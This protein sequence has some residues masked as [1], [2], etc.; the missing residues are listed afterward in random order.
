VNLPEKLLKRGLEIT[1]ETRVEALTTLESCALCEKEILA[2]E[3]RVEA[4]SFP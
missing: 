2:V 4:R 3:E 1:A